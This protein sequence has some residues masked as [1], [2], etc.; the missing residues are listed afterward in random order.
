MTLIG[1]LMEKPAI[2]S[3]A[4]RYTVMNGGLYLGTGALFIVWPGLVQAV[5]KD[6]AFVGH[7]EA[8]VGRRLGKPGKCSKGDSF[9]RV[10]ISFACLVFVFA[11]FAF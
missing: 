6:A 9:Y 1:D 10:L 2:L 7:E 11:D 8:P 4:S 3:A 5:F